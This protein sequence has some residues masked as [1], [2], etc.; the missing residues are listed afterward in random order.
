MKNG[1]ILYNNSQ[2]GISQRNIMTNI[3]ALYMIY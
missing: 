2:H 3:H 1:Y